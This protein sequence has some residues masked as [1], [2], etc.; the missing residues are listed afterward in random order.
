M[1]RCLKYLYKKNVWQS[2][3]SSNDNFNDGGIDVSR[4][5]F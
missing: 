3:G 5:I 4:H 2:E 1:E